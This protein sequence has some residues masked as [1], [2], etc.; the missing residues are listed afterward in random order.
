MA[1]EWAGGQKGMATAAIPCKGI[2]KAANQS[3]S[4]L[5]NRNMAEV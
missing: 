3:A 2:A 1:A 5:T 4:I